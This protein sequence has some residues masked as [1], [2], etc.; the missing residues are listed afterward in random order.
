[1][2][3]HRRYS[4]VVA[5][6]ALWLWRISTACCQPRLGYVR[7]GDYA[8]ALA[9]NGSSPAPSETRLPNAKV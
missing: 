4:L 1:M 9:A 8:S 7:R 6:D 3:I 5:F 2:G